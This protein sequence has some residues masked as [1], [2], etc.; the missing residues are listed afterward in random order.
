MRR[1]VFLCLGLFELAVAGVL[2]AIGLLLP[3]PASVRETFGA[4][5]ASLPAHTN[6]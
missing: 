3:A 6:R 4:P 1:A 5:A 2:L